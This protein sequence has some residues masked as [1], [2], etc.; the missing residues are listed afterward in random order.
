MNETQNSKNLGPDE[1][2]LFD[3]LESKLSNITGSVGRNLINIVV[4]VTLFVLIVAANWAT[5][6]KTEAPVADA[7]V[8]ATEK[9]DNTKPTITANADVQGAATSNTSNAT[10]KAL[11]QKEPEIDAAEPVGVTIKSGISIVAELDPTK[12]IVPEAQAVS[13]KTTKSINHNRRR[14]VVRTKSYNPASSMT[15]LYTDPLNSGTLTNEDPVVRV[16]KS[17]KVDDSIVNGSGIHDLDSPVARERYKA[18]NKKLTKRVEV[19][20]RSGPLEIDGQ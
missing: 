17:Y 16:K 9:A 15:D 7:Q 11:E 6:S 20:H 19:L 5:R 3:R 4:V 2:D 13:S 8:K 14:N 10:E 12:T 1:N 18:Q